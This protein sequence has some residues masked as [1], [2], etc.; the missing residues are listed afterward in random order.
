MNSTFKIG[1]SMLL[2]GMVIHEMQHI[3]AVQAK[4]LHNVACDKMA[5]RFHIHNTEV[6]NN[7]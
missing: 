2:A 4:M 6:E 7:A 1:L 3:I 5:L